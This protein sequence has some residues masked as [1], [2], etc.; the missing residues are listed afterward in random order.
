MRNFI[1][2]PIST[3]FL[4]GCAVQAQQTHLPIAETGI[5]TLNIINTASPT[6]LP[7][8]MSEE[9]EVFITATPTSFGITTSF[10]NVVFHFGATPQLSQ[11]GGMSGVF[12]RN[13]GPEEDCAQIYS[14]FRFYDDG[15][16]IHV[17]ECVDNPAGDF[18]KDIWPDMSK[19]FSRENRDK[20]TPQGIYRLAENKIWFTV[21][22]EYPSHIVI[23]DYF[24]TF[25]EDRLI[26]DYY[27]HHLGD[28]IR[29]DEARE[30]FIRLDISSNP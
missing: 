10:P 16:V 20:A 15:L 5:P 2:L 29:K 18:S 17:P 22:A 28:P 6:L 3:L 19:W 23:V 1:L 13:E 4:L 12:Y 9:T 7:S 26:L 24:G 30:E 27:S 8:P 11:V 21:I 25:S 14:V